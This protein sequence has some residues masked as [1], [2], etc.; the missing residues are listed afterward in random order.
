MTCP[1]L[2]FSVINK[3]KGSSI[4][5]SAAYNSRHKIF[6][7]IENHMKYPHASA[8]DH[9]LTQM[10][11]PDGAPQSYLSPEHTWNDLNKIENNRIGYRLIIP[12]Q[13]ELTFH[14]NM[15]LAIKLLNAEFVSKG[16]PVQI[17]VHR[18]KNDNDHLHAIVADRKLINGHWDIKKSDTMYYLHGTVEV[19]E[20]G[21]VTNPATA[22]IL[23]DADKIDTPKLHKKKLQ[24]DANG[25]IITEKGWQK[26]Q[27]DTNG[28]PMIDDKGYPVL[29]DIREPL[30]IP[31]TKQQAYSNN[32]GYPKKKWKRVT[33]KH[34]DIT[35]IGN[36]VRIRKTWE[37]LQNEA[38]KDNNVTD[39]NGNI[40]A[41]DLRS[42]REQNKV[43]PADDQ[44]IP[45]RHAFRGI[46]QS[47]IL[48]YNDAVKTIRNVDKN[49]R[50]V[51]QKQEDNQKRLHRAKSD[52]EKSIRD[53]IK[54][55]E[56]L[57]P[58]RA[59]IT[60]YASSYEKVM[61]RKRSIEAAFLKMLDSNIKINIAEY[62]RINSNTKKG[63]AKKSWIGRHTT[64]MTSYQNR[65]GKL[66][67]ETWDIAPAA[68]HVF[69]N[70]NNKD[71][72][73]FICSK[74]GNNAGKIAARVLEYT[75]P[76]TSNP[77]DA[78]KKASPYYPKNDTDKTI[79]RTASEAITGNPD[80]ED[81]TQKALDDW[82]R[83]PNE[84]PPEAALQ[85]LDTYYTASEFYTS[86]LNGT[87]WGITVFAKETPEHINTDYHQELIN[88]DAEEKRKTEQK[89]T[90][91]WKSPSERTDEEH[92]AE[93]KRLGIIRDNT[94][95]EIITIAN[96]YSDKDIHTITT[97]TGTPYRVGQIKHIQQMLD[98]KILP[99][100]VQKII[101]KL[102][103]RRKQ[104]ADTA[105]DYHDTYIKK[106]PSVTVAP[107][108]TPDNTQKK[109]IANLA[110]DRSNTRIT[111][112]T[113][114]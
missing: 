91:K 21:R 41:V 32:K 75:H 34:S 89:E 6:D 59:F 106:T 11:L 64:L 110:P 105:K 76:D 95:E 20:K 71:I 51:K 30:Y 92:Q 102:M 49:I 97:K 10:L 109:P 60:S 111:N 45:T 19:D 112:N 33:V 80:I 43:R 88:I 15:E 29:K 79:L 103:A 31:G 77:F 113:R 99:E 68:S 85:I 5:A 3:S 16:H 4:I 22:V 61:Q 37:D 94:L 35:D 44:L 38:Y 50:N 25:N 67:A 2:K 66:Y 24:Y 72:A 74:Y 87:D 39:E 1:H 58:R 8:K 26:L 7:C 13:K 53:D 28:K 62:D 55:Y 63:K 65:L 83:R 54:F 78:N 81:A 47:K 98:N 56:Q 57:N 9:V 36:I 82:E 27:Y 100:D 40:L 70:M 107:T 17:D 86:K 101:E 73:S 14:Q 84:A 23:T 69:D 108:A 48:D 114:K 46:G 93:Y 96:D 18:G 104:E 42:Y 12:F 52:L 90:A